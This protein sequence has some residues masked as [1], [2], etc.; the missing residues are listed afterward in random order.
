MRSMVEDDA[1][2]DKQLAL[3]RERTKLARE[4]TVLAYIRTGFASFLFGAALLG[5][6]SSALSRYVAG[7]FIVIGVLFLATSGL[8]FVLSRRRTRRL[9]YWRPK[10]LPLVGGKQQRPDDED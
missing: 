2:G 10:Y 4:R 1:P 6:F 5:L 8:S 9:L 3:A 7:F